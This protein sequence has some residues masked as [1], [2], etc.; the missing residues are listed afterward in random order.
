MTNKL[1]KT[2]IDVHIK[3]LRRRLVVAVIAYIA[4]TCL[5]FHYAAAINDFLLAPLVEVMGA[6]GLGRKLIF[7]GLAEGFFNHMNI[8]MYCGFIIAFPVIAWQIYFFVA[9][10]LYRSEKKILAPFLLAAPAL[11]IAGGSLAYWYLMPIA[12]SFFISFEQSGA[13]PI[14]LEARISEYLDIVLELIVGFGLAF[15]L[16][17]IMVALVK[18]GVVS[19]K[20][21]AKQRRYAVVV[22]FIIAAVM[23]PPDVISQISLALPLLLLYEI[24]LLICHRIERKGNSHARYKDNP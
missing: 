1:A 15:Q 11:F 14:V 18:L 4:G 10:G 2:S 12:W 8:A 21:L 22:I 16:P 9:P 6:D 23:T 20:S 24:S 7:T 3:E 17:L 19:A 5:C 13:V